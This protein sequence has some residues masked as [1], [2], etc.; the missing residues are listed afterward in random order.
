HRAGRP[1]ADLR[2]VLHDE[3]HRL[4]DGPRAPR[5][6]GGRRR[7]RR[8]HHRDEPARQGELL[9]PL[10]PEGDVTAQILVVDDDA[11]MCA[12]LERLLE[13]RG[14]G[15]TTTTS[16]DEAF[17]LVT[18]GDFDAVVT[19]LKMRG[20]NGVELCDRIVQNRKSLP[21]IV[22]TGFGTLEVAIETLRAGA[23]D[24]L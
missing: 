14:F 16:A 24:F 8:I 21:V 13:K 20:M 6:A 17:E 9:R 3:A 19:D 1:R 5:C 12:E 10:P 11:D 7:A 18:K 15:V 4:R 23:S 2:T 22:V